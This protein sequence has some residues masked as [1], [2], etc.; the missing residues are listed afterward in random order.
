MASSTWALH[1]PRQDGC[2]RKCDND[3]EVRLVKWQEGPTSLSYKSSLSTEGVKTGF[4]RSTKIVPVKSLNDFLRPSVGESDFTVGGGSPALEKH[5]A[6]KALMIL[7]RLPPTH[8]PRR[9]AFSVRQH[10]SAPHQQRKLN[11]DRDPTPKPFIVHQCNRCSARAPGGTGAYTV[12]K[13]I[14]KSS[15]T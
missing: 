11:K 8:S 3:Q 14:A 2:L 13:R 5:V 12:R 10:A 9:T 7:P 6:F 1:R 15:H 4:S